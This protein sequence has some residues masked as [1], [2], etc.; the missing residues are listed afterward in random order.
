MTKQ[1]TLILKGIAF[2]FIIYGHLFGFHANFQDLF[3]VGDK[4][5][6]HF[7]SRAMGPVAFYLILGGYGMHY[8]WMKGDVHRYSRV[9]K[10]FIHFWIILAIFV[11]VGYF[12]NPERYPG[13]IVNI[14]G[15][16][17]AW[18]TSYNSEWWFLFPYVALSLLSPYLFRLFGKVKA[19]PLFVGMTFLGLCTSY[20]VSRYGYLLYSRL[21]LYNPFLI[22]HL[23]PAFMFGAIM[24]RE[25]IV[26]KVRNYV[27][28]KSIKNYVIWG[29]LL[30]L[31][32]VR[33]CFDT[34]AF[35]G[36]YTIA[37]ILLVVVGHRWRI[38]DT[39]LVFLGRHSMNMWLIHSWFCYH[40]FSKFTYSFKHT[41]L[42]FVFVVLSSLLCSMLVNRIAKPLERKLG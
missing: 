41:I 37:F 25:Q 13:S 8:V 12:I 3:Y 29:A 26:E 32:A 39:T 22:L 31:V 33:C 10:L 4:P 42:I 38:V 11:S 5:I 18:R 28:V 14:I 24:Q 16:L 7:L 17:T 15:N 27:K 21:W 6:A 23:M 9:L 34:S 40:L 1:E 36:Y 30:I 19:V 20:I 2:L 35:H